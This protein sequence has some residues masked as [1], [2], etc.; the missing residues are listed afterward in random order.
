MGCVCSC[1]HVPEPEENLNT[2][3][4][5]SFCCPCGFFHTVINKVMAF[6]EIV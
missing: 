4:S 6:D 1:F 2:S 5:G 3:S